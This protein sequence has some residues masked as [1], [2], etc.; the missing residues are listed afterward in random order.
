MA[1]R[2]REREREVYLFHGE[3]PDDVLRQ[4]LRLNQ[5]HLDVP[6]DLCVVWPV[7]AAL[8]L[9]HERTHNQTTTA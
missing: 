9:K 5:R 2:E 4:Q 8:D 6:V 3:G 7:L 1:G